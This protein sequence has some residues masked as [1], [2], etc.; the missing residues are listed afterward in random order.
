[1]PRHERLSPTRG[2]ARAVP[3]A[4]SARQPTCVSDRPLWC[5]SGVRR[6]SPGGWVRER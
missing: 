5:W 1:V 4:G 6:A 2:V 3:R